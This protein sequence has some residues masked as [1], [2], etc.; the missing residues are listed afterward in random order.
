[1]RQHVKKSHPVQYNQ[2]LEERYE[3]D[4]SQ[5]QAE[6]SEEDFIWMAHLEFAYTGQA[7]NQ[8]IATQFPGKS[9]EFI[10]KKKET[11][12]TNL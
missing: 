8:F 7:V 2:G 6:L 11:K 10:K 4:P 12:N 1:M 9:V 3:K 5:E